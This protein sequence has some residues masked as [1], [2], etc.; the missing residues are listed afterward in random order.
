MNIF[1]IKKQNDLFLIRDTLKE[2]LSKTEERIS[3]EYV[4]L[5]KR[6]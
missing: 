2:V 1:K 4:Y 5:L 3:W 6:T